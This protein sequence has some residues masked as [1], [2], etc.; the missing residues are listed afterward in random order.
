V[1]TVEEQ[2]RSADEVICQNIDSL[3]DQRALLSQNVLAQLRNLVEG[4]AVRL[5]ARRSDA[6]FNYAAIAAEL[7]P[8]RSDRLGPRVLIRD[9]QAITSGVRSGGRVP[10][11]RPR[12]GA[13]DG[14]HPD[15]GIGGCG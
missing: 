12:A 4:V 7:T 15:I 11:N 1:S 3:T 8:Y 2:I 13:R 10:L 5:H 14:M 6:E 9:L